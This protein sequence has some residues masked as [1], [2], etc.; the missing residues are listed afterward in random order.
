MQFRLVTKYRVFVAAVL[1]DSLRLGPY[2]L[3][4]GVLNFFGM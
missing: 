4:L 1:E 2:K 3:P